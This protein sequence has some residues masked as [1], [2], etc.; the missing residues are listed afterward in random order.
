[1]V[2]P[3]I[4]LNQTQPIAL[5]LQDIAAFTSALPRATVTTAGVF[6]S[7]CKL[8]GAMYS[9]PKKLEILVRRAHAMIQAG[10]KRDPLTAFDEWSKLLF[11][12]IW[13]EQH[14]PT[15]EPVIYSQ[16]QMKPNHWPQVGFELVSLKLGLG[17]AARPSRRKSL[18]RKPSW[19]HSRIYVRGY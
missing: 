9:L 17:I 8:K 14:T 5:L 19:N 13:D 11:A 2:L 16:L 12:K 3:W 1:M 4:K 18:Q 6:S 15:G 10:G 7:F